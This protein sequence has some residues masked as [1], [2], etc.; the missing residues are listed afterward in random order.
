MFLREL[1][2]YG[3]ILSDARPTAVNLSWAI[4]EMMRTALE[5]LNDPRGPMLD[6]LYRRAVAI[7]KERHGQVRRHLG[8]RAVPG[9]GRRRHPHPCN[10]G[11]SYLPVRRPGPPSC[12]AQSQG[13]T[14][15]VFS[16]RPGPFSRARA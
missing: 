16:G 15:R 8:V 4:R 3:Q 2:R 13:M 6:A 11:L 5:H 1:S 14:F 7:H 9:E 12:W 10:A